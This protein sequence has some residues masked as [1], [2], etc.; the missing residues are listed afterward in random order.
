MDYV[1]W[2]K[3]AN[4]FDLSG[5]Y[6]QADRIDFY[7]RKASIEDEGGLSGGKD[8]DPQIIGLINQNPL[9]DNYTGN[10]FHGQQPKHRGPERP[11]FVDEMSDEQVNQMMGDLSA[12]IYDDGD[13]DDDIPEEFEQAFEMKWKD[14]RNIA[15]MYYD[16]Q[17]DPL[18]AFNS[19]G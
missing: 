6:E 8:V 5:D 12:G 19:S 1:G 10:P 11:S 9:G 7:L 18:Y 14:M 16:G 4:Q 3:K 15:G 13:N 17:S 2:I